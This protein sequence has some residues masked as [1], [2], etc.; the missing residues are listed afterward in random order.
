MRTN[1][2][3]VEKKSYVFEMLKALI[4][5]LIITLV[6]VLAAALIIKLFNLPT[7]SISIVNQVIKGVSIFVS[8]LLCLRLKNCGFIRG[9]ILGILYIA[10]SYVV[11]SLF[12]G[13]F[14]FGINLLNDVAL[15]AVTGLISGI[16]AVNLR[17]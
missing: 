16:I 1:D 13:E 5:A 14:L 8:A 12:N 11:F 7:E 2:G 10:L 9:I 17:K 4:V 3:V 15:G 6:L